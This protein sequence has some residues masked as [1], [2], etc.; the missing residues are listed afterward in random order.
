[1]FDDC[2]PALGTSSQQKALE[3]CL[4]NNDFKSLR[5]CK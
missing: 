1:M 3:E 5:I 4:L 2:N